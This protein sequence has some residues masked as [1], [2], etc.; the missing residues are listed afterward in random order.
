MTISRWERGVV[1][2]NTDTMAAVAEVLGIEPGDLFHHPDTPSPSELLRQQTEQLDA[3]I[4]SLATA[5][6]ARN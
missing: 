5:R 2:M 1:K 6:R 3:A 4:A